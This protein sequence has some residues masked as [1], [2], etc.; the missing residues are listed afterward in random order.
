MLDMSSITAIAER[1]IVSLALSDN[2]WDDN[3]FFI[4]V[5]S[6]ST[7]INQFRKYMIICH[8]EICASCETIPSAQFSST[9]L[10]IYKIKK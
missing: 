10:A 1:A 6:I 7:L 9:L 8:S 2:L 3:Q 5:N 4:L